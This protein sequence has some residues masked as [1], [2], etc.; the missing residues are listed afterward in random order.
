MDMD[1]VHCILAHLIHLVSITF[2]AILSKFDLSFMRL[3]QW[4]TEVGGVGNVTLPPSF[5]RN[6][7]YIPTIP[8][9]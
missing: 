8:L 2:Y 9:V 5:C 4:R 7:R 1:E 3:N 6:I